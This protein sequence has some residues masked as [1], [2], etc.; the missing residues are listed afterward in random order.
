MRWCASLAIVAVCL[1]AP[2]AAASEPQPS[3]TRAYW[4]ALSRR[5]H[6]G[7]FSWTRS[8]TEPYAVC[9][10]P[11]ALRP[12]CSAIVLPRQSAF[13]LAASPGQA[14]P[15]IAGPATSAIG[16]NNPS[17]GIYTPA[18]LRE[19][20]D[21]P[22]E[23]AGSGQ[24][25]AV[26]DAYD[27]PDAES[28]L[29][30]YRS[31]FGLPAC[32]TANGCFRKVNQ[33]GG[34][35]YP[36]PEAH[37]ALEISLDMD[38]V[39]AA[40]PKCHIL[41]VEANDNLYGPLTT[42]DDEAVALGA[43]EIND[44]WAGEEFSA[45]TE[46]DPHFDHPGVPITVSA[47]DVAYKVEYPAASRYV[48]SVGG[49][50]LER[51]PNARGWSE[52]AWEVE[53]KAGTGS[54]C[55][56]YEPKPAWQTDTGCANRT[57]NDIAAV[58]SPATPVWV[59]DSYEDSNE[60]NTKEDPGWTSAGGTSASSPLVAGIMALTNEYTRSFP[61]AEALYE[62]AAQNG[63][64]VLDD[65]V[66]GRDGTCGNYL[67]E[68]IPGYDGP[69]GLGSPWG[70][71]VVLAAGQGPTV[72]Q[73]P[74]GSWVGKYGS[75]GYLLAGWDGA[76]DVSDTPNV[77]ASLVKGSR[78]QW[79]QSTGDARALQS[80]DG[81]TR[82]ASTYYDPN[83]IELKLSFK[84]AY[85]GNLH[86]YAVDWDSTARRETISVN[87]Q[88]L[89]L[90][91]SFN[92]GAWLS[93]PIN[94][95]AGGTVAITVSR[96][97]S[98]NAVLSGV[99]LG[100]AGAPPGP[101]VTSAPQGGWVGKVG[102]EGYDLAGW[103]GPTGDV[104][105]IPNVSGTASVSLV[106][107]SRY[108][109]A[110][111][112]SDPR[113]LSDPGGLTRTASAYYDPNQVQVNLHFAWA[114]SGIMHLY[115]VDWDHGGRREI[116][117]VNGQSAALSEFGEGAWV[118]F[119]VSVAAGGTVTITVDRTAGSNAVLSGI[120]LGEAGTPPG[121]YT[122][123][124]RQGSWTGGEVGHDGYLLAG[125]DGPTGDVSYLPH[126]SVGLLQG[127]RYQWASN[128]SD[129]RALTDPGGL[130]RNAGAYYDPN[131]IRLKLSF[132]AAYSGNLQ[133][134]AVDWDHGGRR[135]IMTV[136]GQSAAL[137]EF[138]EGKWASFSIN[139]AAG[140]T[141]MITVDRIAG[142][143][144]VLSGVFM[145]TVPGAPANPA[146]SSAP[147]GNWVG[148]YGSSGYDLGGW[149]G[150]SDLASMPGESV[151]LAQGSRYVWASSTEDL[152][153][154]QNPEKTIRK[155]ATYY[156]PNEIQLKL[157]FSSAYTGNLRLYAVDWDST[158]R[159]ELISVNGQTASLSSSFNGGA[160]VSFPI[161]V[162]AGET[163]SIVVDRTAGPNAVLSGIFLG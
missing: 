133:L 163:V 80:P 147:Q 9:G 144:A 124:T 109:W 74:Q 110:Q 105:Y 59:V 141:V 146:V 114:Y 24:T 142:S 34:N 85:S 84:E 64:G 89:A 123:S 157:S 17:G 53:G 94:V 93:F 139:V 145:S 128:T 63:T 3:H 26:V 71:P 96:T 111:N 30:Q 57:D 45:E 72:K 90:S 66:S 49:T 137:G 79:A 97:A 150:E 86:L 27:D 115:A 161:S 152:R 129:P 13:A 131:Q 91:S 44:S 31:Y 107:G 118:S 68:A 113:A 151:T 106:Q 102:S 82:N 78:W 12:E 70:A 32:T 39:S 29:A 138:S 143:N 2:A 122:S 155:A 153:A 83:E 148:A 47:G 60:V 135:E 46:L 119:P 6:T 95:V 75:A 23:S 136:N 10:R 8:S 38:M 160:W 108:Q 7:R 87:G 120:F 18:G 42:A 15:A 19:A 81:L 11:T 162:A 25:V 104:S 56:A 14:A 28:D 52:T 73:E 125:W 112:T 121:P 41:L 48:I 100:E 98:A 37:W 65:V 92:Q 132:P 21:L 4:S 140:G 67:C 36:S 130:I 77:T 16:E 103:D 22:S 20:Y 158:A 116:I 76:Q 54:G 69:T 127:S 156:D 126:A 35:T 101:A 50:A 149:N 134:Y 51:A 43:T 5:V 61:G 88:T 58:A 99:F 33:T 154:L 159:R 1:L 62:Q 55:S 117:T 40:C